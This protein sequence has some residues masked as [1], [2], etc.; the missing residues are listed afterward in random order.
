MVD[1]QVVNPPSVVAGDSTL[2]TNCGRIVTGD[3]A[4]PIADGDAILVRDGLIAA[5]GAAAEI[6]ASDV[7]RT[8]DANGLDAIPGLIDPHVH[9]IFGDWMPRFNAHGWLAAYAQ[10]GVTSVVSQGAVYIEGY[11]RDRLGAVSLTIALARSYR[12]WRPGGLKIHPALP[13]VP[14]LTEEDFALL[15]GEGVRIIAEIGVASESDPGKVHAM[16]EVAHRYGFVSCVHFGPRSTDAS[17]FVTAEMALAMHAQIAVHINGGPNAAP[18][19]DIERLMDES[20][21]F[22]E[23]CYTGNQRVLIESARRAYERGLGH[24]LTIGS[25]SPTGHGLVPRSVWRVMQLIAGVCDIPPAE[26]VAIGTG[27]T[28]R[29]FGLNTGHLEVGRQADI[30]LI[31]APRD[32]SVDGGLEAL[33]HGDVPAVTMMMIDGKIVSWQTSNTLPG[34]RA[35]SVRPSPV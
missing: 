21:Y 32:S 3:I 22:L 4:R 16:L 31:D 12:D 11:P 24:R 8:I 26:A 19:S 34:K 17:K 30:L 7:Q 1:S 29:A 14:G 35:P 28:A 23:L 13:L 9:P 6:D 5:V 25:D 33:R 20:D 2:I 15:A 27:N 18:M 10:A